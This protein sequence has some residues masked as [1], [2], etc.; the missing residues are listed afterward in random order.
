[1]KLEVSHLSVRI[2]NQQILD[3]LSFTAETG[4]WLV[5]AGP[6]GAGKSTI[7]RALCGSLP[8]RSPI[9]G[10]IL[11]D[12]R[13]FQ[14]M[15]AKERARAAGL[16]SQNHT[17]EYD[18]TVEEVVRLGRYAWDP[19]AADEQLLS[20]A[21]RMTGLESHRN[22]LITTLSG[23]ELQRVFLAQLF[24]QDPAFLLL[25]EPSNHLDLIYEQQ[26]FDLLKTWA[27]ERGRGIITVMHDLSLARLYG[28][29]VLLLDQGRSAG[30]GSPDAILTAD[31]LEQVYHTDVY[32][33]MRKLAQAWDEEKELPHQK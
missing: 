9:S 16:L 11:A 2:R 18:Y 7:L 8:G 30:F 24:C 14:A 31:R 32:A 6:N 19:S 29:Q 22:R 3:D 33:W 1:M 15:R 17:A 10:T 23:G 25:D 4:S 21:L 27:T 26:I 20:D 12:G 28:D 5:I 13:D